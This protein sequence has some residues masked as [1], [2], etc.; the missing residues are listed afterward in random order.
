MAATRKLTR[1]EALGGLDRLR[2]AFKFMAG[3][4]EAAGKGPSPVERLNEIGVRIRSGDLDPD[5]ITGALTRAADAYSHNPRVA[6]TILGEV[7]NL[8]DLRGDG[9]GYG[10]PTWFGLRRTLPPEVTDLDDERDK[11]R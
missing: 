1:D 3:A 11:R 2:E 8:A 6:R 4:S 5:Q 9:P 7:R 10:N